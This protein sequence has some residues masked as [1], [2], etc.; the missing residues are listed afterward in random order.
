[1]EERYRKIWDLALPLQDQRDDKG[2]AEITLGFA[3]ELLS[4]EKGN[5]DVV[6]PAIIL[7]DI[8]WSRVPKE[9]WFLAL[10]P[11]ANPEENRKI[12]LKHQEEG[13]RIAREILDRLGY[14]KDLI[15]PILEII[16]QHDTRVGSFSLED[17]IVRDADKLWRFSKTGFLTN[18]RRTSIS[19]GDLYKKIEGQINKEGFFFT[20]SARILARRELS[21]LN[22]VI[23]G[24]G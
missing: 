6:I 8:G 2:H 19:P 9:E 17:A 24:G 11:E 20:E 4:L 7:H 10:Q 15:P 14:D 13:V 5:P 1:M 21:G 12:R 18:L 22:S 23:E 3:Q 16:S